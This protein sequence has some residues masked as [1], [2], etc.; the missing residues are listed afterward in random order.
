MNA[1]QLISDRVTYE[2]KR[3]ISLE[4]NELQE[5][6]DVFPTEVCRKDE[7]LVT[8]VILWNEEKSLQLF[9]I[10]KDGLGILQ[11]TWE[12][13]KKWNFSQTCRIAEILLKK[14][15]RSRQ[16]ADL[17]NHSLDEPVDID[18]YFPFLVYVEGMNWPYHPGRE[19]DVYSVFWD[20]HQDFQT[21]STSIYDE[22]DLPTSWFESDCGDELIDD[23]RVYYSDEAGLDQLMDVDRSEQSRYFNRPEQLL[24]KKSAIEADIKW[25][26]AGSASDVF[27]DPV[28]VYLGLGFLAAIPVGIIFAGWVVTKIFGLLFG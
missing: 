14:K 6:I 1:H 21:Y 13:K 19:H 5:L 11:H 7:E 22:D 4:N 25:N 23:T 3:Y 17:V 18:R 2:A 28:A 15:L 16:Y 12:M 24:N 8:W 10:S 27:N 26:S 9:G 20:G